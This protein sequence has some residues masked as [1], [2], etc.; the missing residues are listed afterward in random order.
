LAI[1]PKLIA[2]RPTL[3]FIFFGSGPYN[4]HISW[5]IKAFEMGDLELAKLIA[6]AG[7]FIT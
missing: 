1:A 7:D 2:E 4:L 5:L 3:K 6:Q